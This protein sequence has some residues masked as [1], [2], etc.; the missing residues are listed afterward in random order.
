[1]SRDNIEFNAT[2]IVDI[3]L[4]NGISVDPTFIIPNLEEEYER[5]TKLALEA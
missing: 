2:H 3:L 4:Q 5:I 1:M